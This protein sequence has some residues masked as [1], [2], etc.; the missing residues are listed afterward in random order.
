MEKLRKIYRLVDRRALGAVRRSTP[1]VGSFSS[2]DVA[3]SGDFVRSAVR[4]RT[5]FAPVV[6]SRR[7]KTP[8]SGERNAAS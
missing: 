2:F 3:F 8:R 7:Q 1:S 5:A 6:A 4:F